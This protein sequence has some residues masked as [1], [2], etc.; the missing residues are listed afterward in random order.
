MPKQVYYFASALSVLVVMT[1]LGLTCYDRGTA[2]DRAQAENEVLQ[3]ALQSNQVQLTNL[4]AHREEDQARLAEA[5][6][7]SQQLRQEL[8]KERETAAQAHQSM[9]QEMRAA[10]TSKDVT[11]SELQGKL[12]VN[13]VD[14][15]LFDSGEA[16]LKPEGEAILQQVAKVLA[17]HPD[18]LVHVAGHTDNVPIRAGARGRYPSN[19][20]LST[21]RATA[22]VRFLAEK[23]G[24]DPARLGAIGYGEFHPVAGNDTPEGRA[25]NRRIEIVVLPAELLPVAREARPATPTPPETKNRTETNP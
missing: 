15:V 17:Q 19:W 23:A 12:T 22:A 8:R 10:M 7:A 5:E 6:R 3:T 1:I 4:L 20:E 14:R 18:R 16:T 2:L 25:R 9:E 11:I 24:M 21:A 13:I